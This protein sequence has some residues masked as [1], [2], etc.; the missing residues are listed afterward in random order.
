M[1]TS[2]PNTVDMTMTNQ[3]VCHSQLLAPAPMLPGPELRAEK[4]SRTSPLTGPERDQAG[5]DSRACPPSLTSP[6]LISYCGPLPSL[7]QSWPETFILSSR[8]ERWRC[9]GP[10]RLTNH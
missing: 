1:P 6:G 10:G 3:L 8:G 7:E 4:K 2:A 5:Q 9:P